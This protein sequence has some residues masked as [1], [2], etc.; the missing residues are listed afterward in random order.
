MASDTGDGRVGSYHST[1][2]SRDFVDGCLGEVTQVE[3]VKGKATA[4]CVGN[5]AGLVMDGRMWNETEKRW[6]GPTSGETERGKPHWWH[7]SDRVRGAG[8]H[9]WSNQ[10]R[11][12]Q[13]TC[14]VADDARDGNG[15]EDPVNGK[16]VEEEEPGEL[17]HRIGKGRYLRTDRKSFI[18]QLTQTECRQT[19]I[20]R[21]K[22]RLQQTQSGDAAD[23]TT[24]NP[25]VHHHI[26]Q[27]EKNH[28]DIGSYLRAREGDP[29]IKNYFSRL[30][31]HLL[32]HIQLSQSDIDGDDLDHREP[33]DEDSDYDYAGVEEE[34]LF[35]QE[36]NGSMESVVE[37]LDN[38]PL[39][40]CPI[41]ALLSSHSGYHCPSV[42]HT[43]Y[44]STGSFSDLRLDLDFACYILSRRN[45]GPCYWP[46]KVSMDDFWPLQKDLLGYIGM[47]GHSGPLIKA[48]G[49]AEYKVL[50]PIYGLTVQDLVTS[51]FWTLTYLVIQPQDKDELSHNEEVLTTAV[52]R[53]FIAKLAPWPYGHYNEAIFDG[54]DDIIDGMV[55]ED[56]D[57][58][59]VGQLQCDRFSADTQNY[60]HITTGPSDCTDTY[61]GIS[62]S[63]DHPFTRGPALD[64]AQPIRGPTSRP[65]MVID[66]EIIED[67]TVWKSHHGALWQCHE[68]GQVMAISTSIHHPVL[69]G[70][71]VA[72]QLILP[73]LGVYDRS[74]IPLAS[75]AWHG[76]YF[77]HTPNSS[78][79]DLRKV[80]GHCLKPSEDL[81][82]C[83]NTD[84]GQTRIARMTAVLDQAAVQLDQRQDQTLVAFNHRIVIE[85]LGLQ[86]AKELWHYMI[87]RPIASNPN[88]CVADLYWDQVLDQG[89][90]P[91]MRIISLIFYEYCQ[92]A[93]NRNL[94]RTGDAAVIKLYRRIGRLHGPPLTEIQDVGRDLG[95]IRDINVY[96]IDKDG[97]RRRAT[98][99]T[100][101]RREGSIP[102]PSV[103]ELLENLE[104]RPLCLLLLVDGNK[105]LTVPF[106]TSHWGRES[107]CDLI[108]F[109][110]LF[111]PRRVG[112]YSMG[113]SMASVC[114]SSL[115]PVRSLGVPVCSL[116][117]PMILLQGEENLF[118]TYLH[119]PMILPQEGE[120]VQH[121][122]EY[123]QGEYYEM[124]NMQQY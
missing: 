59:S 111:F 67:D 96:G 28:D 105:P 84:E 92:K 68:G 77:D 89:G 13:C 53:K 4:Q 71:F 121:G 78:L 41:T 79:S 75:S 118:A 55:T 110:Q 122:Y 82:F 47:N 30:Q 15:P 21:I 5:I 51:I 119:P 115:S 103:P 24:S 70:G 120:Q 48:S 124:G 14:I 32:S 69:L 3:R 76:E 73:G 54:L 100:S 106:H 23:I 18:R 37:E 49:R 42:M 74:E 11:N 114:T 109:A 38:M 81:G 36:K 107:L 66:C 12:V 33:D 6:N 98:L 43:H 19:R 26:G 117:P 65:S 108:L 87:L 102:H 46:T 60:T 2:V 62:S 35:G 85:I 20:R 95:Y 64:R 40:P 45:I 25:S 72:Y 88:V 123:G 39:Y 83:L 80:I 101:S 90:N 113:M 93:L 7:E 63:T 1:R 9:W 97:K 17:E 57:D 91:N 112:R 52:D 61:S 16:S 34:V 29:A 8:P 99:S 10:K 94:N 86:M 104:L 50:V 58:S 22:S 31:D 116:H 27:S 56:F 44:Y